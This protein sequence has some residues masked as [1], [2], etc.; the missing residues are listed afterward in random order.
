MLSRI[1]GLVSC[2]RRATLQRSLCIVNDDDSEDLIMCGGRLD[3][4]FHW[5]SSDREPHA[6]CGRICRVR[7][8]KSAGWKYS[9]NV[10]K[11][12][13]RIFWCPLCHGDASYRAAWKHVSCSVSRRAYCFVGGRSAPIFLYSWIAEFLSVL[14]AYIWISQLSNLEFCVCTGFRHSYRKLLG[15]AR[16]LR[17]L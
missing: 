15:W 5:S 2:A 6:S 14:P 12:V 7:D 8:L 4:P 3:N 16:S 13:K 11:S 1:L 9:K 17:S 10:R